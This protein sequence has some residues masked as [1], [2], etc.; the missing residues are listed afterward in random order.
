MSKDDLVNYL[1]QLL[2]SG[3]SGAGLGNPAAIPPAATDTEETRGRG[4]V[5]P[6]PRPAAA[7]D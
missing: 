4:S 5:T 7:G 3:L 6:F 1:T 2:W